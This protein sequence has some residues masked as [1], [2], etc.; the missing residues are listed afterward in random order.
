MTNLILSGMFKILIISRDDE[1]IESW[2]I[3]TPLLHY[4]DTYHVLPHE[5]KFGWQGPEGLLEFYRNAT[6]FSN[7]KYLHT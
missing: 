5:Y 4:I 3:F 7:S 1:L 2:K 6:G